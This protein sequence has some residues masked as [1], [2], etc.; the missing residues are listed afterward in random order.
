MVYHVV[1]DRSDVDHLTPNDKK[2]LARQRRERKFR[3]WLTTLSWTMPAVAFGGFFS[4]WHNISSAVTSPVQSGATNQSTN[5][6]SS[7]NTQSVKKSAPSV[8]FK[9][10]STGSQ[11]SII[12]EQLQEL[13]YFNHT[14]TETYG[15]VTA[16]AVKSFQADHNLTVTGTIDE[17]TLNALKQAVKSQKQSQ[18]VTQSG[19]SQTS[20]G[21][22]SGS[23]SSSSGS[24]SQ[25]DSGSQAIQQFSPG[26]VGQSQQGSPQTSSTAS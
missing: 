11:V 9:V 14:V 22:G 13:G 20:D 8:L 23:A 24:S 26:T 2:Q 3:I 15:S 5:S 10:G 12:Q 25:S 1:D 16:Q 6:V 4:I 18:L 21:S 7:A 17:A 19:T